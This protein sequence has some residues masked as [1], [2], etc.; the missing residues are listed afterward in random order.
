MQILLQSILE[1]CLVI[2]KH[3]ETL[4]DLVFAGLGYDLVLYKQILVH[5]SILEVNLET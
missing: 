2:L 5:V 3:V 1:K 4:A